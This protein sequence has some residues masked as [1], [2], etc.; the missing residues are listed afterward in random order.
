MASSD[1]GDGLAR[2]RAVGMNTLLP[3]FGGLQAP[4]TEANLRSLR[5][6]GLAARR[7]SLLPGPGRGGRGGDGGLDLAGQREAPGSLLGED[8]V[9]VDD[10]V[11]DAS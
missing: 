11:E 5:A 1:L 6:W 9:A 4:P 3:K 10:D 7:A 8:E 2:M